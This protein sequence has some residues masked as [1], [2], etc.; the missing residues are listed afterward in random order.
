LPAAFRVISQSLIQVYSDC[1]P[2]TAQIGFSSVL[3]TW[4]SC[5]GEITLPF[6]FD[7]SVGKGFG[8]ISPYQP[9]R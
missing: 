4:K 8:G 7:W 9:P 3:Y 6:A 2:L 1:R 5:P